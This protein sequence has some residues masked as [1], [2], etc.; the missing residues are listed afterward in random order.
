MRFFDPSIHSMAKVLQRLELTLLG[1]VIFLHVVENQY[2][3]QDSSIHTLKFAIFCGLVVCLSSWI[4]L[5]RSTV[6]LA[7]L[8]ELTEAKPT[9]KQ[10]IYALGSMLLMMA[11]NVNGPGS[12]IL[13]Y[14]TIIKISFFLNLRSVISIIL[15]SGIIHAIAIFLNYNNIVAQAV[16]H[17]AVLSIP[18]HVLAIGQFSYYLGSSVL[19]I[20]L[21]NLVLAEQRSRIRAEILTKEIESLAADLERKRISREIHD[22]LGHTLTTLDI[23]LELAQKLRER[24]P[25]EALAAIDRAKILTTQC[26]QDV[27]LA[28]QNIRKEPFDLNQSLPVLIDRLRPFF[29]IHIQLDLPILPL[30]PS[31]QVYCILQEGFTNIQKHS[32]ATEVYLRGGYDNGSLWVQLEDNGHGFEP[33]AISQGFGLRSMAERAQLL[34]GKLEVKSINDRGT[35]IS[36]SIP[37]VAR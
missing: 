3:A 27:R 17:G 34:G 20:L 33:T 9:T 21:S 5:N 7:T 11:A 29:N 26:L 31:H 25:L 35:C 19:C 18:A 24:D 15:I 2:L 22:A 8:K 10:Q 16:Q 12:E 6:G 1:V 36:L 37:L 13:L 28:V 32:A 23:Q 14:W 4:P 30:Q